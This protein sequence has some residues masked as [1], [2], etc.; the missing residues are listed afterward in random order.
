[1]TSG[2]WLR[3]WLQRWHELREGRVGSGRRGSAARDWLPVAHEEETRAGTAAAGGAGTTRGGRLPA[4]RARGTRLSALTRYAMVR[5]SADVTGR[6]FQ[7]SLPAI[8]LAFPHAD[9]THIALAEGISAAR[10]LADAGVRVTAAVEPVHTGPQGTIRSALSPHTRIPSTPRRRGVL[11]TLRAHAEA[12]LT[13]MA[14]HALGGARAHRPA[15]SMAGVACIGRT[16]LG[17]T[18]RCI[19]QPTVPN[20]ARG[21]ECPAPATGHEHAE[22]QGE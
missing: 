16:K 10:A 19:P 12:R 3:R 13:D 15:R 4:R 8:D 17:L 18:A 14:R 21:G 1:M 22:Q 5:T 7:F 6:T 20:L 11:G 2:D 9:V